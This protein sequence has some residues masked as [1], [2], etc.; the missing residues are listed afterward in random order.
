[1]ILGD[2]WDFEAILHIKTVF[3]RRFYIGNE[4]FGV[5]LHRKCYFL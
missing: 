2:F 1:V 5:I 4:C 3:L